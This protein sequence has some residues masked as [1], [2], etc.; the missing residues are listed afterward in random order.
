MIL[1]EFDNLNYVIILFTK[2]Y[3]LRKILDKIIFIKTIHKQ[4]HKQKCM[5]IIN[6]KNHLV[7]ITDT[8]P[9]HE[10]CILYSLKV[11]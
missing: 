3:L 6:N 8:K 9:M 7:F 2:D 10:V 11:T 5:C 4:I 1:S